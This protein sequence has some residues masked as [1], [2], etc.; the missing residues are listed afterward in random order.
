M[1]SIQVVIQAG[2]IIIILLMFAFYRSSVNAMISNIECQSNIKT[3][4]RYQV[5]VKVI[6]LATLTVLLLCFSIG[7][8]LQ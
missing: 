8:L 1:S 7:K 4:G 6:Y 2:I 5:L 3:S